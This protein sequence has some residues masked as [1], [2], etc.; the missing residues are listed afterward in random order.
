LKDRTGNNV[1]RAFV[2]EAKAYQKLQMFAEKADK[3]GLP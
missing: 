2:E 3:E 1:H